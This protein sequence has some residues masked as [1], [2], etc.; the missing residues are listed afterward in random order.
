MR[1]FVGD[2]DI[3]ITN[4]EGDRDFQFMNKLITILTEKYKIITDFLVLPKISLKGSE[5]FMGV[6]CVKQKHRRIDIKFYPYE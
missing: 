5:T 1:E 2:I 6:C 3:L 4:Q